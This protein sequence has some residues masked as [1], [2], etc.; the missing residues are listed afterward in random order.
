[1]SG[2]APAP[3]EQVLDAS[4]RVNYLLGLV[5]GEDEFRQDQLYFRERDQLGGRALHG[6]GTVAG[7]RV[8]A[9]A[10]EVAVAAGLAI[11]PAGRFVCVPAKQCAQLPAW[12]R[13]HDDEVRARLPSAGQ[14]PAA[15]PLHV[16]LCYRD[17]ETDR[18]PLPSDPCRSEQDSMAPSRVTESFEL[19]LAF[20]APE[21]VGEVSAGRLARF[22]DQLIE[23][24]R[25]V[26]TSPPE[27]SPPDGS[28]PDGSP[29]E[30]TLPIG[31]EELRARLRAWVVR[32]RPEVS[33]HNACLSAPA[34]ACV[35]LARLEL[36]VDDTASGLELVGTPQVVDDDRPIVLSTRFLQEWLERLAVAPSEAIRLALD[37]L[38]DVATA[39]VADGQVLVHRGG[40]WVP[41]DQPV[42]VRDHGALTGLGDAQDHP[43]YLLRDGSRTLTGDLDAA[44]NRVVGLADGAADGDAVTIR[45]FANAIERG[46]AAG[47]DLGGT[48]PDPTVV[49]LRSRT[50]AD[51]QPLEG[52]VL[53]WDQAQAQ[54]EPR[55]VAVA[56]RGPTV[57][58][59]GFFQLGGQAIGPVFN[60]LTATLVD[61]ND[62]FDYRL[63]F[64]G[65]RR[66]A[67]ANPRHMYIVKGTAWDPTDVAPP[68]PPPPPPPPHPLGVFEFVAF[69]NDGIR[70]RVMTA[71]R[72]P[73][74]GFMTEITMIGRP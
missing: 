40:L 59:A 30:Q 32:L 62:P 74:R 25:P 34:E 50:V 11:D 1:M 60:R 66:P 72:D 37:D 4:K 41:G 47:G 7:L 57:V 31:I 3:S 21:P 69:L 54:W 67:D 55:N 42:V 49:G 61:P 10:G 44:G 28:P 17:C 13:R 2:F 53:T 56:V 29:P 71:E 36:L 15:L 8:T 26:E 33:K 22:L 70:V 68:P 24:L 52:Q 51:T 12:L 20:D 73:L 16:L 5:L 6:Y 63:R 9:D 14:L 23:D 64:V 45:Q 39:G 46:D 18:V 43:D 35:P 38:V 58:G 27:L 65:Y 19:K 48:Y